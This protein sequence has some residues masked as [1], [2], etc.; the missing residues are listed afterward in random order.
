MLYPDF[1]ELLLLKS[2]TSKLSILSNR[3]MKSLISGN[4]FSSFH[5]H[6]L[7]FAEARQYVPGDDI[8][9][10]DWR[11]TARTGIPH[12]KLFT[13]ERERSVLMIIDMNKTMRFGTRGTFKSI[14]AARCAALIG[15]CANKN[16]NKV[17]SLLFG[18]VKNGIEFLPPTRSK[19][20]LYEIFKRLC[21]KSDNSYFIPLDQVVEFANNIVSSST[22]VFIISDLM[23]IDK[24]LHQQLGYLR[25]RCQVGLFS[26]NDPSDMSIKQAGNILFTSDET[27]RLYVNT[28]SVAGNKLYEKQWQDRSLKLNQMSLDL[29]IPHI[30]LFTNQDIYADLLS[31]L[32]T[33][34]NSRKRR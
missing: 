34:S 3:L 24:N 11:I 20:S 5:G 18:D 14:Q 8:R 9:K 19:R 21:E 27:K 32:H 13:E 26:V 16:M 33:L 4:Y 23:N 30:P 6:G 2:S 10:M 12:I 1:D 25:N 22:I 31:G 7:E 28:D 29:S 15:W 17:G